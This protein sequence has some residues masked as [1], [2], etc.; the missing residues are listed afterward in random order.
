MNG[1]KTFF[2]KLSGVKT[3][4]TALFGL[5]YAGSSL[6]GKPLPVAPPMMPDVAMQTIVGSLLAIF[7]RMGIAKLAPK[8]NA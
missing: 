2:G 8:P 5:V 6:I 4:G 1:L 7:M 3:Y